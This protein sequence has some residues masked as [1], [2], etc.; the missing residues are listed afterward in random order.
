MAALEFT[1]PS[2]TGL[3]VGGRIIATTHSM[4]EGVSR[5]R[6][7]QKTR[8]VLSKLSNRELEDIGLVR[9]DIEG[10]SWKHAA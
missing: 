1:R 9:G 5:W 8:L 7:A 3:S 4:V 6:N 2:A 10:I